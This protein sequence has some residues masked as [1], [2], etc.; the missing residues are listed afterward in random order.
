MR[1]MKAVIMAGGLGKRI[2]SL[3]SSL[4]KPLIP[5]NNKPILQWEIECLVRQ[6][7]ND[8]I[9]TVSHMA[10]KIQEYFQDG[11]AFGCHIEYF[12]EQERLGNAGALFKLYKTG[13]LSGDFLLL[14]ADSMFDV[15][16]N[17]FVTFHKERCALATLFTHPDNHPYDSGLI[18]A[19]K[20]CYSSMVH[21]RRRETGIL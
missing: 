17:R 13:K 19:D 10:E 16:I 20:E 21:Q 9:L 3:N 8:I 1:N 5:I 2:A 6:G 15:D 7:L 4:P 12:V 14:N 18:V 11:S